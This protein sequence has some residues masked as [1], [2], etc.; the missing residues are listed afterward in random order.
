MYDNES[1]VKKMLCH[2]RSC[3]EMLY[4]VSAYLNGKSWLTSI[5]NDFIHIAPHYN[6]SGIEIPLINHKFMH[7]YI[8]IPNKNLLSQQIIQLG[9]AG[10]ENTNW[11]YQWIVRNTENF[12]INETFKSILKPQRCPFRISELTLSKLRQWSRQDHSWIIV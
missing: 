5:N 1:G 2:N 7:I 11:K 10:S 4:A 6:L 3:R 12:F 8:Q 9:I